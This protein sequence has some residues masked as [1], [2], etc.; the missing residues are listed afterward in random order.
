MKT[1]KIKFTYEP[2]EETK[3]IEIIRAEYRDGHRI[4]L[5]FNDGTERVAD[6][7]SFLCRARHP[8]FKKYLNVDEFK[9]FKI[10]YGNLDWNDCEMCFPVAD[11]YEGKI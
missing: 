9:K 10:I 6:F 2:M 11:L 8:S 3:L 1:K 4:H 7:R 5:W